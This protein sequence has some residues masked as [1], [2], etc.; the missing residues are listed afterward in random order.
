MNITVIAV[1]Y[2]GRT[3]DKQ[4]EEFIERELIMARAIQRAKD[5][6]KDAPARDK[7]YFSQIP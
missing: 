2:W 4:I 7:D 1:I 5:L 6:I 3:K